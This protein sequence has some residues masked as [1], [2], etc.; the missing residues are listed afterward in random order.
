MKI[1]V[2]LLDEGTQ[3][4]RPVEAVQLDRDTYLMVEV[5]ADPQGERWAFSTGARVRCRPIHP[6]DGKEILVA[7]TEI[8]T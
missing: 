3:V 7:Y 2:D 1:Y 8:S 4:W 5:N 6:S